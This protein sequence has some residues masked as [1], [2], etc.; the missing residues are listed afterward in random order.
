MVVPIVVCLCLFLVIFNIVNA[1][2]KL[3]PHSLDDGGGLFRTGHMFI[4][5]ELLQLFSDFSKEIPD[6]HL[7][8]VYAQKHTAVSS[9]INEMHRCYFRK[10]QKMSLKMI[11]LQLWNIEICLFICVKH[12]TSFCSVCWGTQRSAVGQRLHMLSLLSAQ[13]TDL[14][15]VPGDCFLFLN[16]NLSV[17]HFQKRLHEIQRHTQLIL[18]MLT[19]M[20]LPVLLASL[21]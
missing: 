7:Y 1:S 5:V 10:S 4:T 12:S 14:V 19:L 18:Q 21:L 9:D 3:S 2:R 6:S 15:S 13:L 20:V 11:M 17:W 8:N 16:S